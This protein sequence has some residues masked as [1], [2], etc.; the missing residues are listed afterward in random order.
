MIFIDALLAFSLDRKQNDGKNYEND[1]GRSRSADRKLILSV[2]NNFFFF[3]RERILRYA[4]LILWAAVIF[5]ASSTAGAS[6]NTS[7]VI[8]P[9]LEWL[10]P[11]ASGPTIDIYH[12]YI[13]K[14][15]HFTEYAALAF[16]ASRAF[17][18]SSQTI[19]RRFW[20][21]WAF[22]TVVLIASVDEYNQSFNSLRT[23]SIY[24]TLLDA[25]GGLTMIVIFYFVMKTRR[26]RN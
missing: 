25:S 5:T 8:R 18:Y 20:F 21:V 22:L 2:N 12:G 1:F 24:D 7:I 16:L 3:R 6:K 15:A 26:S 10:F 9:L 11:A 17:W 13:R 19:L 4:P 14:L 23:G